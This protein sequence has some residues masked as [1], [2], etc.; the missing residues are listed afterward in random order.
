MPRRMEA[1]DDVILVAEEATVEVSNATSSG[2]VA[3][4]AADLAANNVVTL[5][6]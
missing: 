1:D 2:E 5:D 3:C 4:V 6:S